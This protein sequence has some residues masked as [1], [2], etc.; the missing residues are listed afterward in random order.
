MKIFC[1]NR[2]DNLLDYGSGKGAAMMLFARYPFGKID[3]VE[4]DKCL[5][6]IAENNFKIKN[7]K[8]LISYN[9]DATQYTD[10]DF[11]TYYY[12]NNP[13]RGKILEQTIEQIK[14]SYVRNP[15]KIIIIYQNPLESQLFINTGL[16]KSIFHCFIS[17]IININ[18]NNKRY[19]RQFIDIYC[20]EPLQMDFK[21]YGIK[22]IENACV[23]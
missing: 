17:S 15:R 8:H 16:F 3:G 20:T 1:I 6:E 22:L 10:I 19:G 13:F 2:N 11:Y 18:K 4:Y 5:H 21:K 23:K 9:S 14:N 7:M 12:F